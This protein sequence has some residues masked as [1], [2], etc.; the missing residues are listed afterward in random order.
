MPSTHVV[1]ELP[2][3]LVHFASSV[4]DRIIVD[5]ACHVDAV[6]DATIQDWIPRVRAMVPSLH[7]LQALEELARRQARLLYDWLDCDCDCDRGRDDAAAAAPTP[8]GASGMGMQCVVADINTFDARFTVSVQRPR[9]P[10]MDGRG[11]RP[12]GTS[13]SHNTPSRTALAAAEAILISGTQPEAASAAMTHLS[14]GHGWRAA[15]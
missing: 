12:P 14:A 4:G 15:V 5:T 9:P 1:Q 3:L 13:P 8:E 10:V 2:P 6:L 11:S 7:R